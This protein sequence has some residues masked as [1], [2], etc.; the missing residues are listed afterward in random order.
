MIRIGCAHRDE[1]EDV[2][3]GSTEHLRDKVCHIHIEYI[4]RTVYYNMR[5]Y[6][7][8]A[9]H[10]SSPNKVKE[11]YRVRAYKPIGVAIGNV[12]RTCEADTAAP[13][14]TVTTAG[15]AHRLQFVVRHT[16]ETSAAE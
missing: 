3:K 10:M 16:N 8:D 5:R 15:H 7:I 2:Q 4:V 6:I 1:E 14:P 12:A 13:A 9:S 11:R